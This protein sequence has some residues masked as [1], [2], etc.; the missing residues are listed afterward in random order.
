MESTTTTETPEKLEYIDTSGWTDEALAAG[1]QNALRIIV[2]VSL[3][4]EQ[5]VTECRRL[6][7]A[8]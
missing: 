4:L 6:R 8:C 2:E 3:Q 1:V 7:Q 5:L